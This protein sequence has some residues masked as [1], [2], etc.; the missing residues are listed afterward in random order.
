[1]KSL[2]CIDKDLLDRINICQFDGLDLNDWE[3]EFLDSIEAQVRAGRKL[4]DN[5]IDKLEQIEGIAAE[6]RF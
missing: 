3:N 6:G 1:M 4:T 2:E 5:Q